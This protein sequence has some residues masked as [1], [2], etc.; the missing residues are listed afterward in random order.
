[1]AANR[2]FTLTQ[3]LKKYRTKRRFQASITLIVVTTLLS[4]LI[5]PMLLP[6]QSAYAAAASEPTHQQ[7]ALPYLQTEA[8]KLIS[9]D[10]YIRELDTI[11]ADIESGTLSQQAQ[12]QLHT[13]LRALWIELEKGN[14][15]AQLNFEQI[16]SEL[17]EKKL[18]HSVEVLEENKTEYE[19]YFT[20]LKE[21]FG[22]FQ[23]ALKEDSTYKTRQLEAVTQLR[24]LL[25]QNANLYPTDFNAN[26]VELAENKVDVQYLPAL[27]SLSVAPYDAPLV[28]QQDQAR[29][30]ETADSL[31]INAEI[32]ELAESLGHDPVKIYEYVY[33]HIR[34]DPY[35]GSRKGPLLTLWERSG[36]DI[37]I[38]SLTIAL[39]RASGY[40][41]RYVQGEIVLGADE[42]INWIGNPDTLSIASDIF[43][44][45]G[46]TVSVT[47]DN[48]LVKNHVWVE[49]NPEAVS[50]PLTTDN[51]LF[52]PL[53][54]TQTSGARSAEQPDVAPVG[55]NQSINLE[56][57]PLAWVPLDTSFKQY[58]Y[59]QPL[60]FKSITG[61]DSEAWIDE[62]RP[63]MS[64][65]DT[66]KSIGSYPLIPDPNEPEGE[67]EIDF[68]DYK[69]EQ[70]E[71]AMTAY[72]DANPDLT[73]VDLLGGDYIVTQT[74]TAL[75]ELPFDI[76]STTPP[77]Q[78]TEVPESLE[79]KI[80]IEL[81]D[82]D[83]ALFSYTTPWA[84]VA[85]KRIAL[86]YRANTPDDQATID[87]Y[88]GSVINTPPVVYLLPVLKIGGV[89]VA[90]STEFAY[91]M[92]GFLTR[93]VTVE[94]AHGQS[95]TVTNRLVV[96]ETHMVGLNYGRTSTEALQA[97]Q[98]RL[99][100]AKSNI[101][102][103]S[104][105][106]FDLS[107]PANMSEAV[108]GESL[109]AVILAYYN[110]VDIYNELIARKTNVRWTRGLSV[111]F[112]NQN[113]SISY[114][115]GTPLATRG[116]GMAL[117]IQRSAVYASSLSSYDEDVRTFYKTVG[118]LS[119]AAEHSVFEDIGAPALST[120]QL[121][122]VAML[123]EVPVYR[124]DE[125]NRETVFPKL[126][127]TSFTENFISDLLDNGY[128][129][130]VHEDEVQ[131]GEWVGSGFIYTDPE[132]GASSYIIS[133][134]LAGNFEIALGG[135]VYDILE[136]ITAYSWLAA[137]IGMD[138]W[139]LA[140]G[141]ALLLAPEPTGLSKIIG[142]AL[143]AANLY[144]L[145][146]D[147]ADL[148]ALSSGEKS[149]S[150]YIG[151]QV[152]GLIIGAALKRLGI[153]VAAR[154]YER[155]GPDAVKPII[156]QLPEATGGVSNNLIARGFSEE[157]VIELTARF[158]RRETWETFDA[159][160]EKRGDD[161]LRGLVD[162]RHISN[163]N[164]TERVAQLMTDAPDAPGLDKTISNA[165][166]HNNFGYSYE[167]QRAVSLN[168]AGETI[169]GYGQRVDVEF[170]RVIGF[171]EDGQPLFGA[172][173][174]QPL[175]GDIVLAGDIFV[176][177]KHGAVGNQDIHI[178]NQI[179]KGQAAIDEGLISEYR[180]EASST[181]GKAM[182]DW[183]EM[184]AP[185]VEFIIKIGDGLP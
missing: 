176:D 133:G 134:G 102:K 10:S 91:R 36:N 113:L 72:L 45:S 7:T 86:S 21:Q 175:E 180:F 9:L 74:V 95:K 44:L 94:N 160:V 174:T 26:L 178:W 158:A 56:R 141:F 135:S 108:L 112:S 27:E 6:L 22:E 92:G 96:G 99:A 137:N 120:M 157:E 2:P 15:L 43:A 121:L 18:F 79:N 5:A 118:H 66:E 24:S 78:F 87:S 48:H 54:S 130:T 169:V 57:E 4:Q 165:I 81:Y 88:G 3:A 129:V 63:H 42:A 49:Y 16:K 110:H 111:G 147:I 109:N 114:F 41:A 1:M 177:A 172:L 85:N 161:V 132:T 115:F 29:Q 182:R 143:I 159:L 25:A 55:P 131:L 101:P 31:I 184:F 76:L 146:L 154:I 53:I 33:N 82:S 142:L 173:D 155:M 152:A 170:Q 68:I 97:S 163:K 106:D 51:K 181:M 35:Y 69:M 150:D 105:G 145:G 8:P 37:D 128:T 34:F 179:Q 12:E 107:H 19:Q 62:V 90:R 20:A 139:G 58:S 167:L 104:A 23:T 117:D 77:I 98:D 162:H 71:D 185:D 83:G 40:Q 84:D 47:A 89:E 60:D 93:S 144:S 171:K 136:T 103:N 127:L 164:A 14:A 59:Y 156:R 100:A 65:S 168:E 138:I 64:I 151:E 28:S 183:A 126:Q 46:I 17:L 38:A 122:Q 125:T 116:G 50:P 13:E 39:L 67:Y 75:P 73:N 123:Q 52:L 119:S 166:S 32:I 11:L 153:G 148:N 124:I 30:L 140:A 80:T 149:A 70:A 61:F